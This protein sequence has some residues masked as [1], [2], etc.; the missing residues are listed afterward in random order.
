MIIS[1]IIIFGT[2]VGFI[3]YYILDSKFSLWQNVCLGVAGS[4]FTSVI[5]TLGNMI[6]FISKRDV[7]GMNLYSISIEIIGAII[8]I[9]G[10]WFYRK[11]SKNITYQAPIR[12]IG[13]IIKKVGVF[14]K[15]KLV[16]I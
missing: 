15:N 2:A 14:K 7:I 16:I 5:M 11:I 3:A 10:G 8:F 4:T 6:G 1:L 12:Q 13:L 9:Y